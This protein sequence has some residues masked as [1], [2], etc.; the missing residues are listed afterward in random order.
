MIGGK[1]SKGGEY[2]EPDYCI[3]D[4]INTHLKVISVTLFV[5][6]EIVVIFLLLK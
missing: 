3:L 4:L 6:I 1:K 2:P 5:L